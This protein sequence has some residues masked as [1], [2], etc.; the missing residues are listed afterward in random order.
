[1]DDENIPLKV[2]VDSAPTQS[3]DLDLDKTNSNKK[4][5][6]YPCNSSWTKTNRRL[7]WFAFP[8]V[9]LT[10]ITLWILV[11]SS[12]NHP[13]FEDYFTYLVLYVYFGFFSIIVFIEAIVELPRKP[14]QEWTIWWLIG[15]SLQAVCMAAIGHFPIFLLGWLDEMSCIFTRAHAIC[16]IQTKNKTGGPY[17]SKLDGS[18][19]HFFL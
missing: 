13:Y 10:D 1:M 9:L 5:C 4:T 19:V 17:H 15:C 2:S 14:C 18:R 11:F 12:R 6:L 3:L 7:R 8:I 16:T